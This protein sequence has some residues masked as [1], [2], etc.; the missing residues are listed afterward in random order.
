MRQ[1]ILKRIVNISGMGKLCDQ[2][3]GF[4]ARGGF[5]KQK[6][7]LPSFVRRQ[8]D[9]GLQRRARIKSGAIAARQVYPAQSRRTG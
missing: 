5:S 8:L 6:D 2:R 4:F 9:C 7:N 1:D 3:G